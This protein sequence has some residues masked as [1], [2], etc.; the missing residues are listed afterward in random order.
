MIRPS[1]NLDIVRMNTSEYYSLASSVVVA[2]FV[3]SNARY[4]RGGN[5]FTFLRFNTARVIK[6]S[7]PLQFDLRLLGGTIGDTTIPLPIEGRFEPGVD[8]L[9]MLGAAN[10]DGYPTINPAAVF[11]VRTERDSNRKVVVPCGDN[12]QLYE[13]ASGKRLPIIGEWC[14]L[15]DFVFSLTK[16]Q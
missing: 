14:S 10:A 7:L 11:V 2:R 9:L 4:G 16:T 13:N 8:Y 1:R 6:G 5:I 12:L 3:G 15:D